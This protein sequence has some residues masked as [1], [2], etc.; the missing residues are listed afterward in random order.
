MIGKSNEAARTE[1]FSM[2]SRVWATITAGFGIAAGVAIAGPPS[3]DHVVVVVEEN[4]SFADIIGSAEAPYINS[5]AAGGALFTDMYGITHPSQP[6]YLHL[7]S[8]SSQG[9]TSNA[10]PT[11]LP[12]TTANLGAALIAAGRSFAGFSETL[13]YV[14]YQGESY[15]DDPY[16]TKYVRK[17]NPWINWLA[18]SPTGSQLADTVAQPFTAFPSDYTTLPTVSFVIPNELNNMHDGSIA[19]ADTWLQANLSG[20]AAWAANNNSLL[21]VTWD[22]DSHTAKNRIPTIFYG[23][24]VRQGTVAGTWTLHNLLRTIEDT[25]GT[26]HAGSAALVQPITGAF[27]TDPVTSVAT[28]QQGD[29]GGYAGATDTWIEAAAPTTQHGGETTAT[30]DGSPLS[31]GLLKFDSLFGA[32][33]RIPDDAT[34]LSAKVTVLTGSNSSVN[35]TA[36]HRML[37]GWSGSDTWSSFGGGVATDGV[38]AATSAEFQLIP[39]VASANAIF[40]VTQSLRLWQAEPAANHGWM[41]KNAN[42]TD[43]WVWNTSEATTLDARPQLS[44]VYATQFTIAVGGGT[45]TQAQAGYAVLAGAT[46]VVKTGSGTL[47]LDQANTLSGSMTVQGGVLRLANAAALAS[48]NL[49]VAAGGTAQVATSLAASVAGLDLSGTGL[50]DVTSGALTVAAGLS[51]TDLV[52]RLLAGRNGGTWDGSSGITSSVA[53]A[54]VAAFETR[55]VGWVANGDG[56]V[57]VA[58]A[59]PGDTNLDRVVDILDVADFVAAWKYGGGLAAT[60][61]EGDFTYDGIVDIQDV[62]SFSATGLYGG[63]NYGTAAGI[64]AV[65]EPAGHGLAAGA[66]AFLLGSRRLLSRR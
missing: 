43:G 47:V 13:P 46:P 23:A 52:A 12:F 38:Q 58:Y 22:E 57:T 6:N 35:T 5:L 8:G 49:V 48:S 26:T 9:Q 24:G 62:A 31:Q 3:Y 16:F 50:L 51:A 64:T 17:H 61:Q 40:D 10:M 11:G 41:L 63:P 21:V 60:W 54:Q 29:A 53:A 28:F 65:P 7:F 44:V 25:Y 20:Y 59:A 55:E 45:Q 14:G 2:M 39:D 4:S 1:V 56:S 37:V 42:G 33:G 36:L 34:I 30:V 27:T 18:A 32:A 66:V 19:E 15:S